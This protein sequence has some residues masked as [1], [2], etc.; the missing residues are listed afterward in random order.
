MS[1]V[2]LQSERLILRPFAESDLDEYT[3]M[4]SDPEV[5]RFLGG[6]T[7]NRMEAWRHIAT[8]LG[9]WQL[10]GYGVWAVE[11][12]DTQELVGRIGFICPEG[13][14]GF[15]LGWTLTRSAWGN[16]YAT[17]AARRALQ[18]AFMELDRDHVI[19]LIHPENKPSLAVAKRLGE[20]L[21][22]ETEILGQQVEV[23]GIHRAD[24]RA[25]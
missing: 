4:C 11:R 3:V 10:R 25:V 17:E 6:K 23:W 19:S 2:T 18:W 5:M 15:E 13:W 12:R 7:W 21:E 14:P 22:G 1:M 8:I 16:G 24:W 20:R 9:H